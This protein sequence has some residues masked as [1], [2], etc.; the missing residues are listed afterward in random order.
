MI[1]D[2]M[3][4]CGG[5]VGGNVCAAALSAVLCCFTDS[6]VHSVLTLGLAAVFMMRLYLR[7]QAAS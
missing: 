4:D 5:S 2:L 1:C 3:S 7:I 6:A